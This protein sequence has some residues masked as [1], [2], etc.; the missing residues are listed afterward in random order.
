[1]TGRESQEQREALGRIRTSL[2]AR[3]QGYREQ[4]KAAE[5]T[6]ESLERLEVSASAEFAAIDSMLELTNPYRMRS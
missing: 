1:M 2:H 3:I 6:I 5:R 4:R